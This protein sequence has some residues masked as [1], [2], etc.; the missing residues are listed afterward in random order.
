MDV[1]QWK[2]AKRKW[3]MNKWLGKWKER[4]MSRQGEPRDEREQLYW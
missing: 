1:R 3:D 2:G 4:P